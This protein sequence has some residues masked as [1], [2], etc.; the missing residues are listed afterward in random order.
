[1]G[2]FG[3]IEKFMNAV[4]TK[5]WEQ[6]QR[7]RREYLRRL[8]NN[9]V[10]EP[11]SYKKIYSSILLIALV[12]ALSAFGTYFY[13]RYV[14]GNGALEISGNIITVK[15]G[16]NFQAA[17]ERAKSGDTIMLQSGA[18]FVGNFNLSLKTGGEFITIRASASDNQLPRSDT[19]IDPV[20][21]A[22]VLPKILSPNAEPAIRATDGAHHYRFIGVEFGATKGGVGNIIQLGTT[23]ER[24]IEDLPHHIEFDRVFVHGSASDGQRRGIA[25]NGKFIKIVN[26][27]FSDI[28]RKGEESQAI[29]IWATDGPV[30][31]VNN[32]LEAAAENILFGGAESFLHLTPSDCLVRGNHL[33]KPLKWREEGWDVKNF[34]EIKNGRR[35]RIENNLMTNNW[36]KAQDGTAVLFTT[37]Q[38]SKKLGIIEDIEFTNNIV[39]GSANA[40]NVYGAEGSGGHRLTIRNNFFEDINGEKWGG[41]GFFLKSTAWDG[42]IIEN[43]TI[44]NSGNISV[45][46][47]A[48][49]KNFV[50]RNNIIF[51]KG[52]GFVGDSTAPG[53]AVIDRYFPNADVG[54]NIIVGGGNSTYKSRNFYPASIKQIG[55]INAETG[56]YRLRS[57]SP[58]SNKGLKG[59]PIGANLDSRVILSEK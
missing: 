51:E 39:R 56:D 17:L 15:A 26:S 36:A 41:A 58:Y 30:E 33:N 10:S 23:E 35:I 46:Y 9:K 47:E 45:A 22:T 21:Y 31:I 7:E 57:D 53:Q 8:Q 16:G 49:V 48:P 29:G 20:K 18:S 40:L 14:E 5:I 2:F 38:D 6:K 55:F 37:R 4:N 3:S 42:L 27:Y 28:K 1:L 11:R 59:K 13:R 12:L 44:I 32:Y 19:R 25:A 54:N 43:N 52:Y 24:R 50:F 34:F